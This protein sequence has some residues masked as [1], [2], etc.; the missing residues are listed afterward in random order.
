MK[1]LFIV[2]AT[3]L[4]LWSCSSEP[5]TTTLTIDIQNAG[6]EQAEMTM[7]TNFITWGQNTTSAE[8]NEE[9]L[10][11]FEKQL[12]HDQLVFLTLGSRRMSLYLG[13]GGTLHMS[14]DMDNWEESLTFTGDYASENKF[15]LAHNKEVQ[16]RF[17]Q[18]Q[19]F[20]LISNGTP[21]EFLEYIKEMETETMGF[22]NQ[23]HKENRLSRQFV[24]FF[25]TDLDYSRYSFLI[26]Y[27]AYY[28]HFNATTPNL[29]SD[30]F[31]FLDDALNFTDNH[32]RVRSFAGF[33]G[34]YV[35]YYLRTYPENLPE[36]AD[37]F[38][39]QMWVSN[40]V[41][42]GKARYFTIA[43]AINS[44]LN[45]GDF[46]KGEKAFLEFREQNPYQV[47]TDALQGAYEDALRVAPGN[48]APTFTLNDIEGNPVSLSDFAGKVV[49]LDFWASWCGPCMREVPYAKELKK[50]FEGVDDLVFLY[51]SVDDDPGA[52]RR[53]VEAQNIQGVHLN[54]PGMRAE[55]AESYNVKGVPSFFIIDREGVIHDNNPGRPSSGEL[56]VQQLNTALGLEL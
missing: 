14:A 18:N 51:I 48:P 54:V 35:Q 52:W 12:D 34:E 56:I 2:L 53:T 55:V 9:G 41:L 26:N 45:W 8:K 16:P 7:I 13:Q 49:Y 39:S 38:E 6:F 21:E 3:A 23:H 30:Y 22:L 20:S 5:E 24:D 25:K 1:H 32:F 37:N 46:K 36:D 42:K 29:S 28:T 10:F 15:M 11:V 47:F 44:A 50:E 31:D 27:P 19:T 17:S 4:L 40:N 43:N 33:M